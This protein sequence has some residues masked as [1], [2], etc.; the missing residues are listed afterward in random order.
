MKKGTQCVGEVIRVDFPNKGILQI[1]D[2]KV[3]IKNTLPGQKVSVV[4]RAKVPPFWS[5][6]RLY[7]PDH[8]L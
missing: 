7:L 4:V 3:S 8:I 5:L 6:R 1:E 2:E